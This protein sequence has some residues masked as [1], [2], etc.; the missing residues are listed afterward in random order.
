MRSQA[1]SGCTDDSVVKAVA[2][3]C[4]FAAYAH[5]SSTSATLPSLKAVQSGEQ[6]PGSSGVCHW[7]NPSQ[8]GKPAEAALFLLHAQCHMKDPAS[9]SAETICDCWDEGPYTTHCAVLSFPADPPAP[10]TPTADTEGATAGAAASAAELSDE[11]AAPPSI[12]WDIA[13][14]DSNGADAAAPAAAGISWDAD[15]TAAE[16][17]PDG[18]EAGPLTEAADGGLD[19]I[20]W[21][22]QVSET[23]L[24]ED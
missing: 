2:Y 15:V 17:E 20:K 8:C 12:S 4:A 1:V 3:Y 13:V 7:L 10:A 18:G 9:R 16:T 6:L 24:V 23:M 14:D 21:D 5:G 22:V 11:A 19:A